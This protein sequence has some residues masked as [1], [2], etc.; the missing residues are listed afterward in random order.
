VTNP[1]YNS[2]EVF[3]RSRLKNAH[4]KFTLLLRLA[5]LEGIHRQR[6]T[7]EHSP[8]SCLWVLSERTFYPHESIQKG[9]GTTAYA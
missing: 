3:V 8:P 4:M 6:T 1:P 2:P 5:F 7:F 9:T